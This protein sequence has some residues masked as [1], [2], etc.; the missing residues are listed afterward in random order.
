MPRC[1]RRSTCLRCPQCASI[2]PSPPG[3]APEERGS[4]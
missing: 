3:C 4:A 1:D 2:P